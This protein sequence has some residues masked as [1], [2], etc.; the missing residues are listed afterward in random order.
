MLRD[1][2]VETQH[3]F[4]DRLREIANNDAVTFTYDEL[5]HLKTCADCFNLWQ[6]VI[7]NLPSESDL[8]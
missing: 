6:E 7:S 3:V 2:F 8:I 5:E 1:R 4:V